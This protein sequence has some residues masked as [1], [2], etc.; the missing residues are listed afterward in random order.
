MDL[1][2]EAVPGLG[3]F[4]TGGLTGGDLEDLGGE[5]DGALDDE[6]L[7]LG[8]VDKVSADCNASV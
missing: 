6:L 1:H 8:T 4:T 3:T 2:L 5:T 7:V